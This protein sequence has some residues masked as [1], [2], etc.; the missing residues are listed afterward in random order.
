MTSFSKRLEGRDELIIDPDLPIIDSH[1]HLFDRPTLRYMFDDYLADVQAGHNIIASVYVETQAFAREEGPEILRPLGEIEFANGVA[2][3]SASG[4]YG[5][6]RIGAAIVGH[7]D[8]SSGDVVAEV[9][10]RALQAAPDRLRGVRQITLDHPSE[11]PYRYMTVRP[12]RGIMQRPGFR[13][14]L[15]H[16]APRGLSFDAA[17]FH[18]QL[19]DLAE[20]ASTFP[21]TSIVLNHMGFAV[22]VGL[23]EEDRREIFREWR[24]ALRDVA[25]RPNVVCKV[26]GLGMPPWGFGFETRQDPITFLELAA[27]WKPYVEAAIEAFGV[28]RCMME[29]NF[30]PDGLS[31]GFVPL[32]NA[33]K[34]IVANYSQEEKATLFHGTAAR[35]YRL[36]LSSADEVRN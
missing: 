5:R 35:V 3:M 12:P 34:H 6:C 8:L 17:V 4:V 15:R 22:G 13:S 30:P 2:A 18:N 28:E 23:S 9:L 14:G 21:D 19:P 36:S 7:A 32:W 10:D 31:C 29:S 27:A 26:G 11:A 1:A 24:E 25:R 20:L 16:L 33:L